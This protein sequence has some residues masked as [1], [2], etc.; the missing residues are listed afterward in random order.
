VEGK[1]RE[2]KGAEGR[3]KGWME[4]KVKPLLNKN[5]GYSLELHT[6][7]PIIKRPHICHFVLYSHQEG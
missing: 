7:G 5:S 1:K 4:G 3:G 6:D 2:G